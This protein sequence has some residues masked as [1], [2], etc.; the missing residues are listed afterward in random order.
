MLVGFRDRV[1]VK[2]F[3]NFPSEVELVDSVFYT[4]LGEFCRRN[5][6]GDELK[7]GWKELGKLINAQVGDEKK[8][9]M[10]THIFYAYRRLLPAAWPKGK[11]ALA[12]LGKALDEA[13]APL[14][15]AHESSDH[16]DGDD[17]D[18][19]SSESESSGS[20]T[21]SENEKSKAKGKKAKGKKGDK[22]YVNPH[23]EIDPDS[24]DLGALLEAT[25]AKTPAMTFPSRAQ[26]LDFAK[27]VEAKGVH[28]R[29]RLEDQARESAVK[30]SDL[31]EA[32]CPDLAS[33]APVVASGMEA[34]VK[35]LVYAAAYGK[36]GWW[37]LWHRRATGKQLADQQEVSA[38][39][40]TRP[41]G[42]RIPTD[43]F[44]WEGVGE[45]VDGYVEVAREPVGASTG[46]A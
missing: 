7:A 25:G 42:Y 26:A 16:G 36:Q 17:D 15:A 35:G 44:K 34:G 27:S 2:D 21:E 45:T 12:K 41:P 31:I 11:S 10:L 39:R 1:S 18:S 30:Y 29:T 37:S 22:R 14:R 23:F 6:D 4:V 32:V 33:D 28:I 20:D 5:L 9:I 13:C 8:E 38:F 43:A 19:S 24:L 46:V 40:D 3:A